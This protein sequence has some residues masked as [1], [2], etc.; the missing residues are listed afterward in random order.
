MKKIDYTLE[1]IQLRAPWAVSDNVSGLAYYQFQ[2]YASVGGFYNSESGDYR[3]YNSAENLFNFG[4]ATQA[5][6]KVK[7]L[8]FLW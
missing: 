5:Y 7:K 4:V 3:N 1:E 8:L 2:D 6:R